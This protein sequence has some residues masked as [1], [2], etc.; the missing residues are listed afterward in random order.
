MFL[1]L[2]MVGWVFAVAGL[3]LVLLVLYL[4]RNRHRLVSRLP[5]GIRH[6]GQSGVTGLDDG[7]L[8]GRHRKL[9]RPG[10]LPT[11][12]PTFLL[13]DVEGSTSLWE[14]HP[15]EMSAAMELHSHL[16]ESTVATFKGALP[17]EQ[18]EGDSAVASFSNA[19]D[20][21]KCG[22]AL[23]LGLFSARWPEGATLRVRMALHTGEAELVNGNYRGPTLNRCA[24]LRDTA[25]GG[26][27]VMSEATC[28]IVRSQ[29][30][31]PVTILDLG[32]H[33]LRGLVE[34]ERVF[35]LCHPDLPQ[36]FPPLRSLE[37]ASN[38]LPT[39]LTSF[40][41][42]EQEMAEV[43]ELLASS[44]LVTLVGPGGV[45][46]TRLAHEVA[47]ELL[48]EYSDGVW[49]V[50]LESI[51]DPELVPQAISL[52]LGV[53]EESERSLTR[54]II[55]YLK[56]KDLLLLLDNSEHVLATCA[57]M[58]ETLLRFCPKLKILATSREQLGIA[59]E[60][61]WSVPSLSVPKP[62]AELTLE[63]LANSEAVKLFM[64]RARTARPGFTFSDDDVGSLSSIARQLDG[65]P[66][67]IELAAA[68]MKA[69]SLNEIN[70]RLTD[71]FRFL[72][73]GVRSALPRHQTLQA[74]VDW[75]YDL[76]TEPERALF[77][78]LS[79]FHRGFSLQAAESV[80]SSAELDDA[81]ILHN[82]VALVDKSL[83][84]AEELCGETRY[85][86]LETLREYGLTKLASSGEAEATLGKHLQWFLSIAELAEARRHGPGSVW[87]DR[88][89]LDNENLRAALDWAIRE[90]HTEEALRLAGALTWFWF[91]RG[92][93]TEGRR[94]VEAC[95]G[96][97]GEVS[98]AVRA[99]ALYAAAG[100]ADSQGDRAAARSLWETQLDIVRRIGDE[101][102]AAVTLV[103]LGDS[104]FR[105]G[106][107]LRALELVREGDAIFRRT[108]NMSELATSL[109]LLGSI[110]VDLGHYDQ[111]ANHLEEG[112]R[113]ASN[114]RAKSLLLAARGYLMESRGEYRPARSDFEESL[115]IASGLGHQVAGDSLLGCG[116]V[117]EAMG[118]YEVARGYYEEA[119]A[120]SE[121][122]GGK[123][124]IARSLFHLGV[125]AHN[126]GELDEAERLLKECLELID[127]GEDRRAIAQSLLWLSRI[128]K[129]KGDHSEAQRLLER[130]HALARESESE[131][132]AAECEQLRGELTE[133]TGSLEEARDSYSSALS[134]FWRLGYMNGV[135]RSLDRLGGVTGKLGNHTAAIRHLGA[136]QSIRAAAGIRIPPAEIED[137]RRG[138]EALKNKLGSSEYEQMW[139]EAVGMSPREAVEEVL[140]G[141]RFE[142]SPD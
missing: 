95:L 127:G 101:R 48:D 47:S 70:E 108:S 133:A 28:A 11:G 7:K 42:R 106:D 114:E 5:E 8:D 102:A 38:N 1:G 125:F 135:A 81:Q 61:A 49:L 86:I 137:H 23:Q 128:R 100:F 82:L 74:L 140:G 71:R 26:Q 104:L 90:G 92:Y 50:Q 79:V 76:L 103:N 55:D 139:R 78:R 64:E 115:S 117:A 68:R 22:L 37:V 31:S 27:I 124:E 41:G 39:Q 43:K 141:V 53:R 36:A 87:L 66:L 75:S 25:H 15:E 123:Y 67:A 21:V 46:K 65:I 109:C 14:E 32:L 136:A 13:T 142:S 118:D 17:P 83:V 40:V 30:S 84:V 80:A 122:L 3:A 116:R 85:R 138:L 77:R 121:K 62:T 96:L 33:R 130:A 72:T 34:P 69:F 63:E 4:S 24:R 19:K 119:R 112:L 29:L 99:K 98:P 129:I 91:F 110:E 59:G 58:A 51:S 126:T 111:A 113:L 73:A 18:G 12:T 131:R 9:A 132:I 97:P 56:P 2:D 107:L 6:K 89:E 105:S 10:R 60:I 54:T 88:L 134:H 20:A 57:G 93:W 35:Q 94:W 120:L 45:G 44:R 52:Q 16:I